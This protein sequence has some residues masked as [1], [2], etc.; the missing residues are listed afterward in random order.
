MVTNCL[1]IFVL[2]FSPPRPFSIHQGIFSRLLRESGLA[3]TWACVEQEPLMRRENRKTAAEPL[4]E[5]C[6]RRR[7]NSRPH[8]DCCCWVSRKGGFWKVQLLTWN[9][10]G[11][12]PNTLLCI[13]FRE[14]RGIVR[15]FYLL[16]QWLDLSPWHW[17]CLHRLTVVLLSNP[18]ANFSTFLLILAT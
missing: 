10:I 3:E 11:L 7:W 18:H 1:S 6:G 16:I 15:A 5:N 14:S 9:K 4:I 2:A 13:E 17:S 8:T 12:K